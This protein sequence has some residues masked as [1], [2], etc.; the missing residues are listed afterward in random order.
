V[1]EGAIARLGF[2]SSGICV[3]SQNEIKIPSTDVIENN[4]CVEMRMKNVGKSS[5]VML[6]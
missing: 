5:S 2:V 1:R 4:E 3:G 6:R